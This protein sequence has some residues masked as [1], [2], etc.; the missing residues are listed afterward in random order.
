MTWQSRLP[1]GS[2]QLFLGRGCCGNKE[3]EASKPWDG[4]PLGP[5]SPGTG[6]ISPVPGQEEA[7]YPSGG[8]G[9]GSWERRGLAPGLSASILKLVGRKV[10]EAGGLGD[11]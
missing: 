5:P 7:E 3:R 11:C 9:R 6:W 10:P 2:P 1:P 4:V 8:D